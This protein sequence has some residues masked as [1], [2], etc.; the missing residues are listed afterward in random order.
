[1]EE[2]YSNDAMSSSDQDL[3]VWEDE[4]THREQEDA[5]H[6]DKLL[7]IKTEVVSLHYKNIGYAEFGFLK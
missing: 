5:E 6:E 2:G 1:M 4:P 3:S 7:K